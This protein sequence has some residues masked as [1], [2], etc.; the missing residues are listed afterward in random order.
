MPYRWE[1]VNVMEKGRTMLRV[2][3][4]LVV[5]EK[6]LAKNDSGQ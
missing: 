3:D 2:F 5:C 1:V 4:L 6:L